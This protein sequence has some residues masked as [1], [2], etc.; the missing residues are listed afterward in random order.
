M[1]KTWMQF[2]DIQLIVPTCND[3]TVQWDRIHTP[4]KLLCT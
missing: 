3:S 1:H 2:T 4:C